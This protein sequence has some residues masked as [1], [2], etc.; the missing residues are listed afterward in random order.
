MLSKTQKQ[1]IKSLKQK[2]FRNESACFTVEG[3]KSVNEVLDS[4]FEVL[5]VI[6]LQDFMQSRNFPNAVQTTEVNSKELEELSQFSTPQSVIAVVK[7][8]VFQVDKSWDNDIVLALDDIRDP[9]NLGTI[10]RTADWFGIHHIIASETSAD[11]F[12]SK[13]IQASMGSFTRIRLV[14]ADLEQFLESASK[15]RRILATA[16]EGQAINTFSFQSNDIILIGNEANGVQDKHFK[17]AEERLFIPRFKTNRIQTESLNAA[18]AC[19]I[20]CYQIRQSLS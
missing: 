19:G 5:Q 18:T 16:L 15:K 6:G 2:K 4:D 8:K 9:G 17:F 20:L 13:V 7:Q 10:I 12:N 3:I 11:W 14:Y 1:F